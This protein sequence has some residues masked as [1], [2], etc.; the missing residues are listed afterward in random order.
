M[1]ATREGT[2]MRIGDP[3][4]AVPFM[5]LLKGTAGF[6]VAALFF[7]GACAGLVQLPFGPAAQ[8]L[9][10]VVGAALGGAV[11]WYSHQPA[12]K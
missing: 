1:A 2:T 4:L 10:A 9:V 11:A 8:L 3:A 12:E 7:A 5:T 6:A